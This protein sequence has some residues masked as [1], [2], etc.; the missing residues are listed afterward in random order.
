VRVVAALGGNALLRRGEPLTAENQRQNVARA[1]AALAPI[2]EEHE[3]VISH[4]NGPQVGLLALQGAAY[5]KVDTYPLDVLDAQT[6]GMIGYLIMQELGNLLPFE[7]PLATL[8]TMIEVDGADP[9]F[10]NPTKPIGP[11]Y[12]EEEARTLAAEK[13]WAFKP[14]GEH[15]RRVVPSPKP[16]RIFG[17]DPVEWLLERGSVVICSGGGGIPT[18]YTHEKAPAG[19]RLTGV[20]AVIDKDLASAVLAA[21][22]RADALLIITDV[23]A[24]YDHWGTPQ[25]RAISKATPADM[26]ATK[27]AEGSMG[28]KVKAACQFVEQGGGFA[29]IGS[30]DDARALLARSAGTVI[31]SNP[32][33]VAGPTASGERATS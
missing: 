6:E 20:E 15:M 26:A 14:D 5:A 7:K 10:Q 23:D 27:F 29:A 13:G 11:I 9:A 4:G 28:P 24:V 25:Q 16:K 1:C 2:A 12:S 8:L 30:I 17:V 3:L 31:A 21:D 18:I 22:L 19:R 32:A 33:D